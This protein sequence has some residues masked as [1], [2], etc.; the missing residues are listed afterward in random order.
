VAVFAIAY[1][2]IIL[3]EVTATGFHIAI[4]KRRGF[5]MAIGII[6][7]TITVLYGLSIL[8]L[9]SIEEL[10]PVMLMIS[11]GFGWAMMLIGSFV[12]ILAS[13]IRSGGR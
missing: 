6:A 2:L 12:F 11:P 8:L 7:M 10:Q 3:A 5:Y 4:G 13:L 9:N 1:P